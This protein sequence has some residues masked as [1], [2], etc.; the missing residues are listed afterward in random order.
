MNGI[1]DL[2]T[3]K[4]RHRFDAKLVDRIGQLWSPKQFADLGCGNG[5]YCATFKA[6]GW[7]VVHG[8]EGT[9]GITSLGVYDDIMTMDLTKK[10]WVGIEY[11]LVMCLEVGEHIPKEHEQTFIDNVC[12]FAA[13]DIILSWAVPGQGGKDHVNER[14]NDYVVNQFWDRKFHY[15]RAKSRDLRKSSSL[16]W[17]NNTIM[18]FNR[19][20]G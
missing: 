5:R 3:A 20:G 2:N 12:E 10:R 7:P 6:F 16:K 15:D 17:F 9:Q 19:I 18:V 1:W 13:K 4:K 8:Y 11:D 14:P